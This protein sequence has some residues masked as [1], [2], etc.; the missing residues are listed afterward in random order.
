MVSGVQGKEWL[1]ASLLLLFVVVRKINAYSNML[2]QHGNDLSGLYS[3]QLFRYSAN[4]KR[5]RS[6]I[7]RDK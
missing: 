5:S 1:I 7:E 4:V 3:R 2:D 6:K